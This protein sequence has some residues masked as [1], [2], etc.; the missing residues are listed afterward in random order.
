MKKTLVLIAALSGALLCGTSADAQY[1]NKSLGISV[2]YT[3]FSVAQGNL[4]YG[5]PLSLDGSLYI[6]NGF[7][8]DAHFPVML[9]K[10]AGYDQFIG[11]APSIGV[12]YLFMQE[13]FRP[14]AGL[15]VSFLFFLGNLDFQ[16]GNF[17][18]GPSPNIG[19]DYFLTEGVSVG[20]KAQFNW[21]LALNHHPENSLGFMA[22]VNL[23]F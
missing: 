20:L 18:V 11:L 19:F 14:Y 2:G 10:P 1:A 17:Y 21:Y 15:D 13:A 16:I 9:L 6:E 5:V 7:E 23:W 3:K 4:D 8:L 22:G 12:R